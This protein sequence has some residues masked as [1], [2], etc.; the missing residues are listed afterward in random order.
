MENKNFI[1]PKVIHYCWFGNQ[2][3]P[4]IVQKCIQSWKTHLH[5]FQLIEW[6]ETNFELDS[7]FAQKAFHTQKWA[8][9]A[10]YARLKILYQYGGIYLDTDMLLLKNLEPLLEHN[11]FM[12][13]EKSNLISV[14]IL[15][16]K[17]RHPILL[18]LLNYYQNT[19]FNIKKIKTIPSIVTELLI[20]KGFI[21]CKQP[22]ILDDVSIY[23]PEYFY[24][25][26]F[27]PPQNKNYTHFITNNS[28][29]VHLWESSWLTNWDFFKLG[30]YEKG[31]LPIKNTLKKSKII[32]LRLI[33]YRLLFNFYHLKNIIRNYKN[34]YFR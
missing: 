12:G 20:Q 9:V 2:P 15:G 5:D 27:P 13:C 24:A 16:T 4:L 33:G 28:Y 1:I 21:G 7:P 25:L 3:K 22:M 8:F 26:P 32:N 19:L 10:D 14:G 18:K 23:P 6:N 29:A 31:F 34:E 17:P 30:N 11:I